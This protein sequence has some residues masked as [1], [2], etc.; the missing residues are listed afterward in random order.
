MQNL[1]FTS[2]QFPIR[3]VFAIRD[4]KKPEYG[5][6]FKRAG[7]YGTALAFFGYML[8]G[9]GFTTKNIISDIDF[10]GLMYNTGRK[11]EKHL[12]TDIEMVWDWI[13]FDYRDYEYDQIAKQP[14][15]L[16]PPLTSG[17]IDSMINDIGP[18]ITQYNKELMEWADSVGI[19]TT[20]WKLKTKVDFPEM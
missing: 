13:G 3:G 11:M 18:K 7:L 17:Q 16:D 9:I 2:I 6:F 20:T 15:V 12:N 8:W 10:R 14:S 1:I 19:D 4:S 5:R